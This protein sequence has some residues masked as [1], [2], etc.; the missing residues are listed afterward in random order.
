MNNHDKI[1]CH[2]IFRGACSLFICQNPEEVLAHVSECLRGT[3][4]TKG[5]ETLL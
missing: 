2:T 4:E 1:F 5:W 3:W